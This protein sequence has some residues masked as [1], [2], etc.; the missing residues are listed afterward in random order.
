MRLSKSLATLTAAALLVSVS[1]TYAQ[2][3]GGG[4]GRNEGGG[5][6]DRGGP[7]SGQAGTRESGPR[8]GTAVPRSE[9][10][11]SRPDGARAQRSDGPRADANRAPQGNNGPRGDASRA[12]PRADVYRAQRNDVY[13]QRS[14]RGGGGRNNIVVGRYGPRYSSPRIIVSPRRFYRPYYSFRPRVS[15][16]FGLWVGYPVSYPYSYGYYD[17]WSPY[18]YDYGYP[19]Y[20][21]NGYPYPSNTYPYP[22]N[23]YPYPSNTYPYPAN[24]YPS[25][26]YP[27]NPYPATS[28]P[29]D[30]SQA[31]P[32]YPNSSNSVGVQ[33]GQQNLGGVSFDITPNTAEVFIDGELVGQVGQFA[34]S[35]QPL[36]L[37]PGRHQ[38]EV[39]AP[40]Y[41][42]ISFDA[43]I[44]AGQV[45]P[46]QGAMER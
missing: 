9:A 13:A 30:P 14:Y 5:G 25:T 42:T 18:G 19:A 37:T 10:A 6:R 17:P 41:R 34:P 29:S 46:Y 23:G 43:D 1:P 21:S 38:I 7:P 26:T 8:Q 3:R 11:P 44:I 2:R 39:R 35:T 12:V 24:G 15:L 22:S 4:Q 16:G 36:G 31:Y 33:P 45:I 28:Y 27:S 40:G 32:Q 20:P